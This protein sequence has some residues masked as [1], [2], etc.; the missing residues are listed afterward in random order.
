LNGSEIWTPRGKKKSI[1]PRATI[2][3][4]RRTPG[5]NLVNCKIYKESLEELKEESN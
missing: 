2:N 1:I 5:Y 3:V 4:F